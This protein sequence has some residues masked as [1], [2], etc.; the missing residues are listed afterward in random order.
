MPSGL[1]PA[2]PAVQEVVAEKVESFTAIFSRA[3]PKET[4]GLDSN[5]G[6][7]QRIL[8]VQWIEAGARCIIGPFFGSRKSDG[9]T[10]GLPS[11]ITEVDTLLHSRVDLVYQCSL[12][13]CGLWAKGT[14]WEHP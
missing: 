5:I 8:W 10:G 4:A 6:A 9:G 11:L 2:V 14:K 1:L 13:W 3:C 12:R 7:S